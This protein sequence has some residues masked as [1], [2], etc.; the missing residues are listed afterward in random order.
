MTS[1]FK[2]LRRASVSVAAL[3]AL[4]ITW[5]AA[6]APAAASASSTANTAL[7]NGDSVTTEDGITKGAAPISLE[8]F[9]AEN[10]GYNVTV[11][12]GA[13]WD[14]MTAAEFA[15]YQVL[16]VGDPNCSSTP[17]SVNANAETWA[18]VV[19]GSTGNRTLVG[20]D[21]E[22]HYIEGEGGAPPT[23][24]ADPTTAGAEHLVQDGITYAGGV[25]GATGLYYD[26]SCSD[27]GTDIS[28]LDMLTTTGPGHWAEAHPPCAGAVQLIASNSAFEGTTALT[29]HDLNGWECSVHISFPTFP[30]DWTPMAIATAAPTKP[31]CGTDPNTKETACGQAYVL[32]SGRGIVATSP[33][34]SLT[35]L[36]HS[37]PVFGSHAVTATVVEEEHVLTS[38][39]AASLLPVVETIVS[40]AVTGQ[41]SGVSGVCTYPSGEADPECKTDSN[42]QVVFTY[43]DTKGAGSD[44]I[45]A[46][47]TLEGGT[48]HA[49]AEETWTPPES[50]TTTPTTT[51]TTTT[52]AAKTTTASSGVLPAKE[53][54]PPKGTAR[55]ASIR[56]CIAQTGYLAAVHG[57]SIA[58]VTFTLDGH[59]L[60]TLH[61]PTSSGTFA[62]RINVHAGSAH[63]L[64]EHVVF[65]ASSKTSATTLHR[66]LA[67]CA[68]RKATLPSFTG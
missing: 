22:D 56:G 32:V 68:V 7:I 67:R 59:K 33:N 54:V 52:T 43:P 47:V 4:T 9:A 10:A 58:S 60:K 1:R 55:A 41:N 17:T 51:T 15:K 48:Q 30:A 40:F 35:P 64:S 49:T 16:I 53:S 11:V 5:A 39:R 23:N 45:N 14:A 26:T 18:P 3:A 6:I 27:P 8:Q 29:T 46:S 21:P 42:G 61:K 44:T 34:L 19:M 13:E 57:T 37:D 50:T 12:S 28:V 2:V 66:T 20:T 38:P 62:L 24:P 25:P 36:T 65:T 31:T 63:H